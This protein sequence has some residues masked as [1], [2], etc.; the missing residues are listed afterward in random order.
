MR[1][2]PPNP[3]GNFQFTN[4]FTANLSAAGAPVT[5]TGN[6]FASFLLGQVT[7]FSIDSQSP[8]LRP[9]ANIVEFFI[10]DDWRARDASPSTSARATP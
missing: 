2:Q 8:Y 10:Q 4:I 5:N 9:R 7:R 6:A 3:T 1:L